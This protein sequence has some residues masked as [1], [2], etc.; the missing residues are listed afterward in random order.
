M[1]NELDAARDDALRLRAAEQELDRLRGEL[2]V[3]RSATLLHSASAQEDY[4]H[5]KRGIIDTLGEQALQRFLDRPRVVV[6]NDQPLGGTVPS[7][8]VAMTAAY[9]ASSPPRTDPSSPLP[10]G[11]TDTPLRAPANIPTTTMRAAN[12][13]AA[14]PFTIRRLGSG[15]LAFVEHKASMAAQ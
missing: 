6:A 9:A 7:Y 4:S 3:A 14:T 11:V 13:A 12:P 2:E 5:L 10:V 1:R 15:T 8:S